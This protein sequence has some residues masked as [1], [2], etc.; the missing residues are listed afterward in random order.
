M[1]RCIEGRWLGIAAQSCRMLCVWVP[2]KGNSS[3]LRTGGGKPTFIDRFSS[4]GTINSRLESK[5]V[6]CYKA[7]FP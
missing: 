2:G 4:F 5:Y 1:Q 7:G 3:A 6:E